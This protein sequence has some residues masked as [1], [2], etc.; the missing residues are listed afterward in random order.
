MASAGD[1]PDDRAAAVVG[2]SC[3]SSHTVALLG[4]SID[5]ARAV[6]CACWCAKAIADDRRLP[7]TH[8]QHRRQTNNKPTRKTT[9]D[10]DAVASWGRGED[11]QLGHGDAEDRDCPQAVFALVNRGVSLVA[12]GAEY[13]CVVSTR[14][15]QLWS[16]GWG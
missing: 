3:G 5:G 10:C 4:E 13:S 12:C 8:T 16:W 1:A 14:E 15:K 6:R 7:S 9:K 11:G 2:V